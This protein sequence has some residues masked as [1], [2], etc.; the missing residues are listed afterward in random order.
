M[1]F[2]NN[3]IKL[4]KQKGWSQDELAENLD[5]SR[6]AISKW[7]NGTSKPDIDNIK[8]ISK[9]FDVG[10]DELLSNDITDNHA[11]SL[12]FDSSKKKRKSDKGILLVKCIIFALV[13][14]YV[15][16]VIYKLIALLII[17]NGVEKYQNLSNYHYII[18]TYNENGLSQKEECWFKDG[19]S[20]TIN[21]FFSDV[22][23]SEVITYINY[24]KK[25]A[26]VEQNSIKTE[27]NFEEYLN[28]YKDYM[29]GGQLYDN[30][31]NMIRKKD[32]YSN[33]LQIFYFGKIKID[34][35]KKGIVF[36]VGDCY[37]NLD[38]ETLLPE[39][40]FYE[41]NNFINIYSFNLNSVEIN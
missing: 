35:F 5:L 15:I 2:E 11:L 24:N 13:I 38:K 22:D 16:S 1:S 36:K 23:T 33:L 40:V 29:N 26:Y 34:V 10:I 32:L 8:R 19:E 18:T 3:L 37:I 28:F 14:I 27:I 4:R 31:P 21:I 30:L 17:V 41:E 7:E 20:K 39:A 25:Y 9:V 12:D 6:Q